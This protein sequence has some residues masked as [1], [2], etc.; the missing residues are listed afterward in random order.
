MERTNGDHALVLGASMAGLL[1]ARVVSERY[2]TVTVVDRDTLP[3]IGEHRRGVPHGRHLHG[4]LSR[5]QQ[6]IEELFPGLTREMVD[7]GAPAGDLLGNVRWTF[8]GH[9]FRQTA[10]GLTMLCVRRPVLEGRIRAR[11]QAL[12][13]VTIVDRCDIVGLTATT[14]R[15]RVTGARVLSRADGGTAEELAADLVVDATGRGSRMPMWLGALGYHAAGEERVRIG[16]GYA[17]RIVRLRPGALGGDLVITNGAT[18]DNPRGG[19][20]EL[21]GDGEAM[22]TLIGRLGDDP[23]TDSDGFLAFARSLKFP[24]IHDAIVDAEPLDDSVAFRFP[25]SVRRR[26][27]ELRRFPDGLLVTG[28]A[29]CSFNPIYAQGMTVAALDALALQRE[30]RRGDEPQ[31]RR[32]FADVARVVDAPWDI[33]VGGDLAFPG[34]EGRRTAKTRLVN[35]YVARLHAAAATDAALAEAFVRVAAL[36]DRPEQLLR[37]RVARRVLLAR[38]SHPRTRPVEGDRREPAA[39]R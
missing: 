12:P 22:V 38:T 1:A 15:R 5:G 19:V 37:P 35:H 7:G 18:I 34:V 20:L 29:V 16:I 32:F 9:R 2:E 3:A 36:V 11:V 13:N 17:T 31:S 24:D 23:P 25:A 27:E 4:L 10:T 21:L 39:L 28:D 8:G 26:Y 30:L 14:D 33:A 6:V